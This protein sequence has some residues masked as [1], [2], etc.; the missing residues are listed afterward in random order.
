M[1]AK[2]KIAI[3]GYDGATW[4][5]IDPLIK[6]GKLPNLKK[7]MD[8]GV[9]GNLISPVDSNSFAAWAE[10]ATGVNI[11]KHSIFCSQKREPGSYGFSLVNSG[12]IKAKTLWRTIS[13]QDGKVV[14]VNVPMT[15]PPEEVKGFLVSGII[16]PEKS[17]FTYPEYLTEELLKQ[18]YSVEEVLFANKTYNNNTQLL[19]AVIECEEKR[20]ETALKLMEK[21]DWELFVVVFT[22]LDRIQHFFWHSMDRDHPLHDPTAPEEVRQ[23][24][25]D[26]Y[27]LLDKFMGR[28]LKKVPPNTNIMV[29][30]DHG[31]ET[32]LKIFSLNRWL[33][34]EGYLRWNRETGYRL[35]KLILS[36][37]DR[38][39]LKNIIKKIIM[40][41]ATEE[42]RKTARD[43]STLEG[44]DWSKTQAY[45]GDNGHISINLKGREPKGIV[46][47][48]EEYQKL[49]R[50][51]Q[52]KLKEETN[53]DTG[54]KL[55]G[56]VFIREKIFKGKNTNNIPDIILK[57]RI[58]GL[59]PTAR[60][61]TKWGLLTSISEFIKG[62]KRFISAQHNGAF[63][64]EG[65]FVCCGTGIKKIEKK[66]ALKM[67]DI[68]PTVLYLLD[69]VIPT[70]L[71][72]KI[73]DKIFDE[74]FVESRSP[75]F[76]GTS[77]KEPLLKTE[78]ISKS[79]E[80][81]I[82]KKLETLGY[83]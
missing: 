60:L 35:K 27:Q 72:G 38:F 24:I 75:K 4:D 61:D 44:I 23:A 81:K 71:D 9:K 37:M 58:K 26:F 54:E 39:R 68:F 11:D 29:I 59:V 34:K 7:I 41:R 57:S 74:N 66:I 50:E 28:I 36:L 48:G 22:G 49:I 32:Y 56:E 65:I 25:P 52:R 33:N 77:E 30:S 43:T 83:L 47:T 18:E 8:E 31:F 13:D 63:S 15:Y 17:I 5:I 70:N 82:K 45:S 14:I 64:R 62:K 20:L 78:R 73:K 16:A 2:N 51:I 21:I 67:M 19:K 53:L 79:E 55:F 76:E 42:L 12:D 80:E 1:D 69:K 6:E 10:F 40:A 46:E 3:I